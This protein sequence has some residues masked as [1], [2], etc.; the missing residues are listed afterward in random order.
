MYFNI[1]SWSLPPPLSHPTPLPP[2]HEASDPITHT[3]PHSQE[4]DQEDEEDEG[5]EGEEMPDALK[6]VK[7]RAMADE[8]NASATN[9]PRKAARRTDRRP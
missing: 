1:R 9:S 8:E 4:D 3:I 7:K 2:L 5:K 6:M